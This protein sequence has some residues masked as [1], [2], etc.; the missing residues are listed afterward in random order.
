M[1]ITFLFKGEAYTNINEEMILEALEYLQRR[2]KMVQEIFALIVLLVK[3]VL[4]Y[5]S[6]ISRKNAILI[7][8]F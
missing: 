1:S 3:L 7:P 8:I 2:M 6:V 5:E 4:R